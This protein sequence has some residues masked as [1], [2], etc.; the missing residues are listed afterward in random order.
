MSNAAVEFQARRI[1]EI[2]AAMAD[3]AAIAQGLDGS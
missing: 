3:A 1:L 2:T